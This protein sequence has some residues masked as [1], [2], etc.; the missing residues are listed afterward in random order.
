MLTQ[1]LATK[2]KSVQLHWCTNS[3]TS[4]TYWVVHREHR[5]H[6]CFAA[7]AAGTRRAECHF[8]FPIVGKASGSDGQ[9]R[10]Y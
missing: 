5:G 2:G 4:P 1:S 9:P 3:M 10:A 6:R 8:L 7:A